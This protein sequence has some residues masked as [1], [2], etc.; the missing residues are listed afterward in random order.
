[1]YYI[2]FIQSQLLSGSH[3]LARMFVLLQTW[4]HGLLN[5]I[6]LSHKNFFL[7]QSLKHHVR[8][9]EATL[10]LYGG[11]PWLSTQRRWYH[12]LTMRTIQRHPHHVFGESV[13]EW[14]LFSPT[15]VGFSLSLLTSTSLLLW[16]SASTIH[17]NSEHFFINKK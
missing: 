7:T 2:F 6:L 13:S 1:M 9:A 11:L 15:F 4:D 16:V 3:I 8:V 17:K 10:W 12:L 14:E 5:G